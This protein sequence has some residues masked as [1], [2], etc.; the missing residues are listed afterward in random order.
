MASYSSP[1]WHQ[2]QTH[3]SELGIRL[4]ISSG[5]MHMHFICISYAFHMHFICIFMDH[6]YGPCPS[7]TL[8][9]YYNITNDTN[10]IR[11][12][13]KKSRNLVLPLCL[14][15]HINHTTISV[16]QKV[17]VVY[18][19][20]CH[21]ESSPYTVNIRQKLLFGENLGIFLVIGN[22]LPIIRLEH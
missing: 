1:H 4:H 2:H 18:V 9:I 8:H 16:F 7:L 19:P 3:L 22:E 21:T 12:N 15:A 17:L 14:Y 13:E 20:I 6:F 5:V 11:L 10:F